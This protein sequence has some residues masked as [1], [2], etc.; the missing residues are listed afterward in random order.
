MI[1]PNSFI[2]RVSRIIREHFFIYCY[3]LFLSFCLISCNNQEAQHREPIDYIH[4]IP[5]ESDSIPKANSQKGEVLIA[6]SDCYTCH[7]EDE[8]LVGPAFKD[9]AKR[10][11][12]QQRFIDM[13]AYKVVSGGYGAWGNTAMSDHSTVSH[14]DA[15][16]MV[17]Y[18]LSLRE[19]P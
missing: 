5:G 18:I 16:L 3:C 9:I 4:A 14:E 11:P 15:K 7:K 8:K 2:N 10:Y 12:V 1:C 6:Y 13:L 19:A 17:S